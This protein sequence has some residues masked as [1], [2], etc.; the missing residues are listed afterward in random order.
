MVT[1]EELEIIRNQPTFYNALV[2]WA[3][4]RDAVVF[5]VWQQA[6]SQIR[7]LFPEDAEAPPKGDRDYNQTN[8]IFMEGNYA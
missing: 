4:Q 2:W 3:S 8:F 7:P 5:N 6:V 1:D